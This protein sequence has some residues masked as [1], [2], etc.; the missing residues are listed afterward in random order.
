MSSE[1]ERNVLQMTNIE[2]I[3]SKLEEYT[4]E[5]TMRSK[6][7]GTDMY[8]C[9]LCH[10]GTPQTDGR[11][12]DGAFHLYGNN[13]DKWKCHACG[14]GGTIIDLYGYL[15]NIDPKT[16]DGTRE[17]IQTLETKY[18]LSR[19]FPFQRVS[20]EEDFKNVV[21]YGWDGNVESRADGEQYEDR[22]YKE[23]E[24][25]EILSTLEE[26]KSNVGKSDYLTKRGISL[27]V[28][29]QFQIG[30]IPNYI[31]PKTKYAHAKNPHMQSWGTPRI[32]I[33]TSS[34]SYLARAT[35]PEPPQDSPKRQYYIKCYK[36]G[37]VKIFNS[38]A[39]TSSEGYCFV[40]EGEIDALSGIECDFNCI[41]LGSTSNAELLFQC[42]MN[43]DTVLIIAMDNDQSGD[44]ATTKLVEL[45]R[46]HKQP[47][48][49]AYADMIFNG[50]KDCNEALQKDRTALIEQL[51]HY[52][53]RALEFDKDDFFKSL[54]A[55]ALSRGIEENISNIKL[56][57]YIFHTTKQ[58][59]KTGMEVDV[60]SVCTQ[61]L[62]DYIRSHSNYIF[63]QDMA[64]NSVNRYWYK[65]GVY[66]LMN[67]DNI[68]GLIK[69]Y[70]EPYKNLSPNL[71]KAKD[72][73]EVFRDLTTDLNFIPHT[74]LNREEHII[75]FK[76]G[77]LDL[78]TMQL[79]PH[80]PAVYSTIQIPCNYNPHS[81]T[82]PKFNAYLNTLTNNNDEKK[83]LLL[84]YMG[85]TI[86]NIHGYRTKKSLFMVGKGDTGKSQIKTL[87]E[88]LVGLENVSGIDL[89]ELEERF[90]TS[91]LYNKRLIGSSDMGFMTVRELK[92]FK[93][94]T[95]GDTLFIEF[96]GHNGFSYIYN[97]LSW[98]CMNKLPKFGG[99][100]GK[101]VYDRM[102]IFECNN[103]IP[104]EEQN[105]NLCDEM[106]AER[107][108]IINMLIPYIKD[109]INN[110]YKFHIPND[111]IS[112]NEQY[113]RENN[114]VRLFLDECTEQ[115]TG[116][117]NCSTKVIYEV[118]KRWCNDNNNGYAITNREFR[119]EVAETFGVEDIKQLQKRING[120][121]YYT[122]TLTLN[123]KQDYSIYDSVY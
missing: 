55:E 117:D 50:A 94:I 65:N 22:A 30:F 26:A 93:K 84:E 74:D 34:N 113:Q 63:V 107:E 89:S 96:K 59:K 95:G 69:S 60:Y 27:E 79:Y 5:I 21:N 64:L 82:A 88:R 52:K 46:K 103:T 6:I 73:L 122:F 8:I 68:K 67:D 70:I 47:Y 2:I 9:P 66:K 31:H 112:S 10:S 48:T 116:K 111:C 92:I 33:P 1:N 23:F 102:I 19:D 39:L 77:L 40:F 18:N 36:C 24:E 42:S 38:E 104:L 29:E 51:E 12:H 61:Y 87:S 105:A 75:N 25:K 49:L 100:R 114:P 32:I 3:K 53:K 4:N 118:F 15:N 109:V 99:D 62:A 90:G 13:K 108:A 45:C 71:I 16:K 72:I 57:P 43:K 85:V 20:A 98:F 119:K 91:N 81:T 76:N 56:P 120:I 115:R 7:A 14:R 97:G 78:N 123:A 58:D 44:K 110:G 86:S 11:R 54:E 101:W 37:G 41:G 17:I 121:D 106:F 83:R 35:T 28:Q 80:T